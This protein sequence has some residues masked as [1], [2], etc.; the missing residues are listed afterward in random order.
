MI[1][2]ETQIQHIQQAKN[3]GKT[4]WTLSL[5]SLRSGVEEQLE[6][7]A[8][9]VA[10]GHFTVPFVPDIPN[11]REWNEKYPGSLDHSK[12][13][14]KPEDYRDKVRTLCDTV[15]PSPFFEWLDIP[16]HTMWI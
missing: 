6:Y 7:D 5:R 1:R 3:E 9:V 10:S 4:T 8:V 13:F 16:R 2:F 15:E 12:F 14:R 11:I